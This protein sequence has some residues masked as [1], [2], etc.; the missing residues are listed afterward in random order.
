MLTKPFG[1]QGRWTVSISPIIFVVVAVIA[2]AAVVGSFIG[3]PPG[4]I[5]SGVYVAGL[6]VGNLSPEQA[7]RYVA[8]YVNTLVNRPIAFHI[9]EDVLEVAPADLGV[10]PVLTTMIARA[11]A[12]GNRGSIWHQ[13]GERWHAAR[14]GVGIPLVV[15]VDHEVL[16]AWVDSVAA[17]YERPAI[18]ARIEVIREGAES[19]AVVIPAVNGSQLD[20]SGIKDAIVN[21]VA[22]SHD[23]T[24]RLALVDVPAMRSTEE[25]QAYGIVQSVGSFSTRFDPKEH[26]RT[27]NIQI[28][29]ESL[30]GLILAPG[31]EFSFNRRVGPRIEALG[32][33]EAPVII[34]GELVP[35]I[36]GGVCQ[37][38]S[39]LYNAV[40]LAGLKVIHRIAHSIPSTYV[41]LGQDA[42]V[43]Y[44]YLDFRFQN[45]SDRHVMIHAV[46]EGDRLTISFYGDTPA[47]EE[48][49]LQSEIVRVIEPETVEVASRELAPG[50]RRVMNAGRRGY[51]VHVWR[52]ATR[53]DGH[54]TKEVVSRSSYKPANRVVW[55]GQTS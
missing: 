52:I 19:R 20:R 7:Q 14:Q 43:A 48:V 39:T 36:G 34:D 54:V 44:D 33:K 8:P 4:L 12:V 51:D 11:Y 6:H 17:A 35:D 32:Y 41:P 24:V 13:I 46:V 47:Y 26:N 1:N 18:D 45:D 9:E 49:Y 23:R 2:S 5:R 28:A 22:Q 31:E 16:T 29:A 15:D 55:V 21:A 53:A 25:V 30:N 10:R 42:T 37:V 27:V 40:L 38:S 3:M 50:Q